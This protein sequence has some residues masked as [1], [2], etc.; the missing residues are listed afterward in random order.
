MPNY[1]NI[2]TNH[3]R[4]T[5]STSDGDLN[6]D[7]YPGK[8]TPRLRVRLDKFR[9]EDP[10]AVPDEQFHE[11]NTIIIGLIKDWDMMDGELKYPLDAD[12][13]MDL[14]I[15]IIQDV[16]QAMINPNA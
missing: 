14:P 1:R 3:A 8:I 5:V 4:V 2:L 15:S 16:V 12:S 10:D 11:I 13:M 6:V 9:K 7:Y